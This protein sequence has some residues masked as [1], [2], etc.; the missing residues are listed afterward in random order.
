MADVGSLLTFDLTVS[1]PQTACG[2]PCP[3]LNDYLPNTFRALVSLCQYLKRISENC[4]LSNFCS[5]W[6]VFPN[7]NKFWSF[8]NLLWEMPIPFIHVSK[9]PEFLAKEKA[10]KL[11]SIATGTI[12]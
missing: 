3:V 9:V 11:T 2:G 7:F 5:I 10:P 6:L 12:P 8:R 1:L 4:C